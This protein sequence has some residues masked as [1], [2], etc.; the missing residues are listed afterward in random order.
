MRTHSRRVHGLPL[1]LVLGLVALACNAG[2]TTTPA[3]SPSPL[4]QTSTPQVPATRPG[5]RVI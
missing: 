1:A 5:G 2:R 4:P 3:L